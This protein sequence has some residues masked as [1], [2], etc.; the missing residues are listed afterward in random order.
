MATYKD[1]DDLR[2][3]VRNTVERTGTQQALAKEIGISKAY[4]C[5]FLKGN[6]GAGPAILSALGF[7]PKPYYRKSKC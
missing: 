5:D 6:R 1:D 3:L 2:A 7:E 4:L